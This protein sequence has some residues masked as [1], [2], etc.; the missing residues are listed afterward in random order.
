MLAHADCVDTERGQPV[1]DRP[2]DGTEPD[3]G[4]GRALQLAGWVALPGALG[5]LSTADVKSPRE[6]QHRTQHVLGDVWC[7]DADGVGHRDRP[8]LECLQREV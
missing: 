6:R 4:D 5:R 3:D 2:S 8:A 1:D 7:V